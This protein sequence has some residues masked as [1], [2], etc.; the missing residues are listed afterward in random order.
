LMSATAKDL[1]VN[2]MEWKDNIRGGVKYLGQLTQ[3]F[4]DPT[5]VMA[6]TSGL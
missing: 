2:R 3:R 6:D 4:Q 1:G 5:L